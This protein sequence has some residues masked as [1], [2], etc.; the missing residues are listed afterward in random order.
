[1]EKLSLEGPVL[2]P[3]ISPFFLAW[4]KGLLKNPELVSLIIL[5]YLWQRKGDLF[6]SSP[7]KPFLSE[8]PVQTLRLCDSPVSATWTEKIWRRLPSDIS[9]YQLVSQFAFYG[10]PVSINR[11]LTRWFEGVYPLQLWMNIPTPEQL[12]RIQTEGLRGVTVFEDEKHLSTMINSLRDPF[13]FILHDLEHADRFFFHPEN[14]RGQMGFFKKLHHFWRHQDLQKMYKQDATFQH[15]FDY[16][17]ADMNSYSVHM[18]QYMKAI[19]LGYFL[20]AEGKTLKDI[21]SAEGQ[22][23]Y[24]N[25]CDVIA[26]EWDM[27]PMA[28]DAFFR[29]NTAKFDLTKDASALDG[30][31]AS[32]A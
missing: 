14:Q 3:L 6:L 17:M 21:L 10:I 16:L 2:G 22:I 32:Q 27:H 9:L 11:A 26:R 8:Q 29:L 19:T 18:L 25:F 30:F 4:R 7:L 1:M 5:T 13:E 12:L 20:R 15:E 24:E 28:S 31:F 23:N